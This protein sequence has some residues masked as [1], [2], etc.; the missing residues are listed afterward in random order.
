MFG[1]LGFILIIILVIILF[2]LAVLGNLVRFVFGLGKGTPKRDNRHT[3]AQAS[4]KQT[5][6]PN[7]YSSNPSH[8]KK[9]FS[10]DDGE[11]VEFEDV[12]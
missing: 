10:D 9:I 11:Y 3:S 5:S 6:A 1:F 2:A 8:K 4:N 12:D 7:T